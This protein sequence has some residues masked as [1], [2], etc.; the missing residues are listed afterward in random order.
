M[1]LLGNAFALVLQTV[2]VAL[3]LVQQGTLGGNAPLIEHEHHH[4]GEHRHGHHEPQHLVGFLCRLLLLL[5]QGFLR[6]QRLVSYRELAHAL[7]YVAL[8]H[9][10]EQV[11][12]PV[13]ERQRL[14]LA[15]HLLQ[16][17]SFHAQHLLQ[18]HGL[19]L[20][21]RGHD[22]VYQGELLVV[23]VLCAK[24][25]GLD[26]QNAQ[27]A[28]AVG[29]HA[30]HH[31]VGI[32]HVFVDGLI[33]GQ[34]AVRLQDDGQKLQREHVIPHPLHLGPARQQ[35]VERR[36]IVVLPHVDAADVGPCR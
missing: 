29:C 31:T 18:R 6:L 28:V 36:L 27:H 4:A 2:N 24:Q 35:G 32:S 11:E 26:L 15:V 3:L 25:A 20:C 22:A 12:S 34:G 5:C 33:I 21:A 13:H 1:K 16:T 17:E 10:V 7:L 23:A 9:R 19:V 14:S 8:L 30:C